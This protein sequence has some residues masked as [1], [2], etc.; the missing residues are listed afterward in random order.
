MTIYKL[1]QCPRN[2]HIMTF[3][4]DKHDLS[5]ELKVVV[6]AN[7]AILTRNCSQ[8]SYVCRFLIGCGTSQP[9]KIRRKRWLPPKNAPLKIRLIIL[10]GPPVFDLGNF[11]DRCWHT[12]TGHRQES[13]EK[14]SH[15]LFTFF[16]RNW[17]GFCLAWLHHLFVMRAWMFLCAF[18]YA[19]VFDQL[20]SGLFLQQWYASMCLGHILLVTDAD[21]DS[22]RGHVGKNSLSL[23]LLPHVHVGPPYLQCSCD[24]CHLA[25]RALEAASLQDS[26]HSSLKSS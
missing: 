24:E 5:K 2:N 3:W 6:F 19:I 10:K 18:C 22:W 12:C 17:Q 13:M 15:F 26:A 21:S 11:C 8:M 16:L 7:I 1:A 25:E 20:L 14:S 23:Y 4:P 9:H